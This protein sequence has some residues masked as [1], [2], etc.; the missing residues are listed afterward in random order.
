MK[1][2]NFDLKDKGLILQ[3][4]VVVEGQEWIEIVNQARQ[5]LAKN[6]KIKGFRPG[7]VPTKMVDEKVGTAAVLHH[8]ERLGQDK[9]F[10]FL[11]KEKKEE[12]SLFRAIKQTTDKVTFDFYQVTFEWEKMPTLQ[13]G[14]YKN[15]KYKSLSPKITT[16]DL[17]NK[18]KHFRETHAD[19]QDTKIP[20]KM[21]D[22][23]L[24][25]FEGKVDGK[26]LDRA[27][28]KGYQLKLGSKSFIDG[29]ESGLVGM[30]AGEE[31]TLKLQFPQNYHGDL[32]A[33][34][35]EFK[36][37]VH[38]VQKQNLLSDEQLLKKVK[39]SK[40]ETIADLK[41]YLQ[42]E[43]KTEQNRALESKNLQIIKNEIEKTCQVDIPQPYL[44][45]EFE[46]IKA[47]E[48]RRM[49]KAQNKSFAE[50]L[51]ERK[52]SE[53]DFDVKLQNTT[54]KLIFDFLLIHK[55]AEAEQ[56]EV[57]PSEIEDYYKFLSQ[58]TKKNLEEVKKIYPEISLYSNFLRLKIDQFLLQ[59]NPSSGDKTPSNS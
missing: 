48:K 55:I 34:K 17:T 44:E 45:R 29:F 2:L 15:I 41:A 58:M 31:K 49:E 32:A 56:I 19:L 39:L 10:K 42:T 1:I 40:V 28:Q 4:A 51:Q 26:V 54:Q 36:I 35:V 33:K 57:K 5:D 9:V 46:R 21:E 43:I 20:A 6:L 16:E 7:Q 24:I 30:Q 52:E 13:L 23:L 14:S 3:T 8:A 27:S 47:E 11:M 25:D 37:K 18:M 53:K 12:L 38:K 59:N 50:I 22:L